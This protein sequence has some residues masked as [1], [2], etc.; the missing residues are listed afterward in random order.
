MMRLLRQLIESIREL[1]Q[2][3]KTMTTASDNLTAAITASVAETE[4]LTTQLAAS[5]QAEIAL[6]N[7]LN[8]SGNTDP[9]VQIAADALNAETQRAQALVAGLPVV[10]PLN[11]A[12]AAPATPAASA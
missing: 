10:P 4:A 6:T 8:N 5:V 7:A 11:T 12:Q 3:I 2:R 1:N 9:A